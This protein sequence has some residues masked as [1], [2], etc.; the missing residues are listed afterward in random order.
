MPART[1]VQALQAIV[2]AEA[3]IRDLTQTKLEA[4]AQWVTRVPAWH[5]TYPDLA[6]GLAAVQALLM[7]EGA[8]RPSRATAA[9][10]G[11]D[12]GGPR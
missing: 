3:V 11:D 1:P 4:L 7:P 5:L 6:S 10:G 12:D 9:E 2:A 8:E